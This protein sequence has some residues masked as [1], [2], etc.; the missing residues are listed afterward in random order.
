MTLPAH[1]FREERQATDGGKVFVVDFDETC[2]TAPKLIAHLTAA[3]KAYG[4]KIYVLTGNDSPRDELLGRLNDYGI[5]FDDL[6]QYHDSQSDGIAR[7]HYLNQLDAYCGIDNRID[8][9][10]TYVQICPHLFVMAEPP[11][12]AK[13]NAQG[14]KKA[15]KKAAKKVDR[16]EER[17]A[18][19]PPPNYRPSSLLTTSE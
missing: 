6:I 19:P 11:K 4:D 17:S 3:L 2:T 1:R 13:E 7:A 18:A 16:S 5:T 15:A 10:S 8:R 14:S 9:A 12:I